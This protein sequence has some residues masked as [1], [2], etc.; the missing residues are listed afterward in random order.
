MKVKLYQINFDRDK[1]QRMF[2]SLDTCPVQNGKPIVN[3]AI[4]D[5]V[6]EGEINGKNPEDAFSVFNFDQPENFHGH[7]MSVSDV[8]EIAESESTEAGFYFCDTIGFKKIDFD[9]NQAQTL[10]D[11]IRVVLCE[12]GKYAR[13]A[14]IDSSLRGLQQTVGG[15]IEATYPF[16][17]ATCIV[18]NEEGKI[19]GLPLNRAIKVDGRVQDII[20]GTFFIC[21]C[22]TE[23]FSSL[24]ESQQRKYLKQFHY[25]EVFAKVN[26][27]IRAMCYKPDRA[28]ER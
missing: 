7:S 2:R 19:S 20:A 27:E 11:T 26:G 5:K 17:E 16:D 18:C 15:L 23:R 12:P 3:S 25:P 28:P 21:G 14:D 6:F 9:P 8:V 24:T 10:D 4:Y 22:G 13:I 1:E